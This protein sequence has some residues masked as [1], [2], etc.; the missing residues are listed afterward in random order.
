M[1]WSH[2][3]PKARNTKQFYSIPWEVKKSGNETWPIY[4]I[5]QKKLFH[6]KNYS[7]NVAWKLIPGLFDFQRI[8]CKKEFEGI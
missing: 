7:K 2:Q 5:L 3:M 4:V 8:L 1:S 6:Q